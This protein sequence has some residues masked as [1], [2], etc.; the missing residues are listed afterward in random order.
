MTNPLQNQEIR[1][2]VLYHKEKWLY[3]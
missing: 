1:L 2:T 3:Q